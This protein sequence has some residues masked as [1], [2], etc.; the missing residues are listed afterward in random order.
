MQQQIVEDAAAK[1]RNAAIKISN[2]AINCRGCSD[3]KK[4]M[5]K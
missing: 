3:S 2:K 1:Y 4:V 5:Q